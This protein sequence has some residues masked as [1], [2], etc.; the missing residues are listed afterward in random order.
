MWPKSFSVNAV[1]LAKKIYYSSRDIEFFLGDYFFC[2]AV[3][4]NSLLAII[5]Y[6][7]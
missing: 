2:R 5:G 1:N 4:T 7:L 6:S 3:Y